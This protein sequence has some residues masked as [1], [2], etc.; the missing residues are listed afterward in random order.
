MLWEASRMAQQW[1]VEPVREN[2]AVDFEKDP[3]TITV[4]AVGRA[5]S[6]ADSDLAHE[7]TL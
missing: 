3:T 5:K 7:K 6:Y 1:L 4:R 2:Q